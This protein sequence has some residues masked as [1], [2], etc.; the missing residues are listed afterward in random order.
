MES[1]GPFY[2]FK[3]HILTSFTFA[4]KRVGYVAS[5]LIYRPLERMTTTVY[6]GI[7]KFS[8]LN[9]RNQQTKSFRRPLSSAY[10]HRSNDY[11][12]EE[13]HFENESNEDQWLKY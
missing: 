5:E 6:T 12:Y 8:A 7:E 10:K 4:A 9:R 11:N 3:A 2:S 13:S 1:I